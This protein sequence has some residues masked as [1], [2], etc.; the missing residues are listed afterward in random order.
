ML[1]SLVS[2]L[3]VGS[4]FAAPALDGVQYAQDNSQIRFGQVGQ[5]VVKDVAI[6][7]F[8]SVLAEAGKLV[9]GIVEST[10]S[11]LESVAQGAEKALKNVGSQIKG[12]TYDN[13]DCEFVSVRIQ[14][15]VCSSSCPRQM[16]LSP[17]QTSPSILSGL[18]SLI[19]V[20]PT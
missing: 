18:S 17:M 13:A 7:S 19:F 16:S 5:P 4:T 10:D 2:V 11:L 8:D 9:T 14:A 15:G 1:A 6:D 12:L 3:L 20:I